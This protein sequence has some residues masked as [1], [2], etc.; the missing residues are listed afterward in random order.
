MPKDRKHI[1]VKIDVE[2]GAQT[3]WVRR[4]EGIDL[5]VL[6]VFFEEPLF[7]DFEF[8]TS[9]QYM[10]VKE[11]R[12]YADRINKKGEIDLHYWRPHY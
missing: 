12:I 7:G 8:A 5:Y 6:V 9:A 1:R 3:V 10:K 11:A 2:Q 4:E